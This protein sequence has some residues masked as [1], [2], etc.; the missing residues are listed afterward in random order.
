MRLEFTN[1]QRDWHKGMK[2]EFSHQQIKIELRV[3]YS[4]SRYAPISLINSVVEDAVIY[5]A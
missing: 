3:P 1:L 4:L 2:F 5:I